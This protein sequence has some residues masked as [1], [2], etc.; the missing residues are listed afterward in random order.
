MREDGDNIVEEI[1]KLR[2]LGSKSPVIDTKNEGKTPADSVYFLVDFQYI[3][4]FS[5]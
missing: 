3:I 2:G 5:F 4:K 1:F